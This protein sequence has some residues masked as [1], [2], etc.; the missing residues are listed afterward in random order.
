MLSLFQRRRWWQ[1]LALGF[2][3]LAGVELV[4]LLFGRPVE[5]ALIQVLVMAAF[6]FLLLLLSRGVRGRRERRLLAEG[7]VQVFVRF[8]EAEDGSL[9][10]IWNPGRARVT[11]GSVDFQPTQNLSG[12]AVGPSLHFDIH[13][14]DVQR[15]I[16]TST[17]SLYLTEYALFEGGRQILRLFTQ[18]G[19]LDVASTPRMLD[20]LVNR[21][22][23]D[24][25]AGTAGGPR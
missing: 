17:E 12:I 6:F 22:A 18:K 2:A 16:P 13:G 5:D 20:A 3:C 23:A 19:P 21:L 25:D 4:S 8:P 11:T 14:T 10:A 1:L 24:A 15:R 9:D 7:L